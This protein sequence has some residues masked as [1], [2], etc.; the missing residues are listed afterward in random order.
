MWVGESG[1]M[2]VGVTNETLKAARN[3]VSTL[4][5]WRPAGTLLAAAAAAKN[6]KH[7][8]PW[9]GRKNYVRLQKVCTEVRSKT[10]TCNHL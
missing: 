7:A 8:K 2:E 4:G 10:Q 1:V 6:L 5:T 3:E 9:L